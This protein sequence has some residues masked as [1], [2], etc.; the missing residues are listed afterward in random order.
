MVVFLCMFVF[1]FL[2]VIMLWETVKTEDKIFFKNN[3]IRIKKQF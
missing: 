3:F 2:R 1:V